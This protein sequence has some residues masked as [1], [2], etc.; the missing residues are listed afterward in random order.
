MIRGTLAHCYA[1]SVTIIGG[2]VFALRSAPHSHT[3][4]EE[5]ESEMIKSAV[6]KVMWVGTWGEEEQT[7]A[8][9]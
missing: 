5:S 1:T 9:R 3:E 7:N 8:I 4:H 2:G 6:S